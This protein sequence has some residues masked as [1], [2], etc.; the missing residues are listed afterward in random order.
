M[1]RIGS[2]GFTL[3]EVILSVAIVTTGL[4]FIL[5]AIGKEINVV[6]IAD[7][8]IQTAL[9]LRQKINEVEKD[10][11]AKEKITSISQTGE[12]VKNGKL[13]QWTLSICENKQFKNLYEIKAVCSWQKFGREKT[14]VLQTR[15]YKTE[16][17][18][19]E[20]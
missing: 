14:S 15:F 16:K 18:G 10:L 12:V 11:A 5:Q 4:I 2:R 1:L 9:F 19:D 7:D 3:V 6:S 8:K 20:Q 13:Y 17:E